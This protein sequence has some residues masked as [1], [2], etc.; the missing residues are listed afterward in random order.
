MYKTSF[1]FMDWSQQAF[2]QK[3]G[4][5]FFVLEDLLLWENNGVILS[6][7]VAFFHIII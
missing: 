3:K 4:K 5:V 7:L 6:L 1:G 2:K